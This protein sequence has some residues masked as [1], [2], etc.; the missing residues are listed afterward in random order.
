MTKDLLQQTIRDLVQAHHDAFAVELLGAEGS[1]LSVERVQELVEAG[2]VDPKKLA[3][4]SIPGMDYDINPFLFTR[5]MSKVVE[6]TPPEQ[7]H[8]LRDWTLDQWKEQV[9]AIYPQYTT[10][11]SPET[12][13]VVVGIPER[14]HVP[15]DLPAHGIPT[16]DTAPAWMSGAEQK[17]YMMARRNAGAYARRLGQAMSEDLGQE[18][19]ER[20]DGE[21]ILFE[22]DAELRAER[23]EQ[24]REAVGEALAT[25]GDPERLAVDLMRRTDDWE[26]NWERIARTE[27]Q[28]AYSDGRVLDA[29]EAYGQDT[30]IARV[31]EAG[32]CKHCEEL[33]NGPEGPIVWPIQEILANGTNVGRP[34]SAWTASIYPIHP[35]CRC[36][37]VVV[38]PGLTI[39]RDG[40]LRRPERGTDEN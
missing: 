2:L 30:Q 25:H 23:L 29:M 24:I 20:W 28:A 32:A 15:V 6:M 27:I 36:D 17:A 10:A 34:R 38:P 8:E 21:E 11:R 1:G 22:A 4:F 35:N 33:L 19:L 3:G 16:R 26:H 5:L 39:D 18:V 13:A 7:Q 40:R 31:T 12:G 14:P 9:Q 37:T